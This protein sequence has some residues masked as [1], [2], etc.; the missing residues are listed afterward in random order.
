MFVYAE[1]SPC[2]AVLQTCL[3]GLHYFC[4]RAYPASRT[5]IARRPFAHSGIHH[6]HTRKC[7]GR[8]AG[9]AGTGRSGW[10][11]RDGEAARRASALDPPPCT[12]HPSPPMQHAHRLPCGRHAHRLLRSTPHRLP[13][14]AFHRLPC[15]T[16][17]A[18][19]IARSSS[20]ARCPVISRTARS[21]H[22]LAGKSHHQLPAMPNNV[23]FWENRT[24]FP[25]HV[26]VFR[27]KNV[28]RNHT[29][30]APLAA[31]R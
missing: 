3:G 27:E 9:N 17:I 16:S 5:S 15:G 13:R 29:R 31:W 4:P 6:A 11:G 20:P 24:V 23:L 25:S 28:L 22:L 1:S 14:G 8:N 2:G 7:A 12:A 19:R 30:N 26:A 18:S 21:S 10:G